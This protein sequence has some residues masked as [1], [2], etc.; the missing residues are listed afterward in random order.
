MSDDNSRQE[1]AK[2]I[3]ESI[4]L[5]DGGKDEPRKTFSSLP[6][7]ESRKLKALLAEKLKVKEEEP[8]TEL[9]PD[10]NDI[11]PISTEQIKSM[12]KFAVTEEKK[13]LFD[14]I[15][16]NLVK[17]YF[18]LADLFVVRKK[19]RSCFRDGHQCAHCGEKIP[20]AALEIYHKTPGAPEGNQKEGAAASQTKKENK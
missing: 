2:R 10:P 17:S 12:R 4:K 8:V 15:M 16:G 18:D 1:E 9:L 13:P 7:E 20:Y 11:D 3:L 19:T 14:L 5:K 6:E